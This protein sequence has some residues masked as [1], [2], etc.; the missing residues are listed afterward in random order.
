[1]AR[2]GWLIGAFALAAA[3][4]A[5]AQG[6]RQGLERFTSP[7][8]TRFSGEAEF[9]AYVAALRAAWR[10]RWSFARRGPLR[11]AQ[12]QP[13]GE[14]LRD[15]SPDPLCPEDNPNCL[16]VGDD[17]GDLGNITVTGSRIAPR[18]ASITNNQMQGVDEGDIVKQIGRFL[19]ILSDG[20]IFTIDTRP[21]GRPG[22]A[23]ASR[24]NVYLDPGID[25]WYDEMLVFGDRILVAGYSY[26]EEHTVLSVFRLDQAGR[27]SREGTFTRRTNDYYSA[28]NYATRLVGDSLVVYSIYNIEESDDLHAPFGLAS[29]QRWLPGPPQRRPARAAHERR[30]GDNPPAGP[31]L[32]GA[33]ELYRP[34]RLETR[35]SIHAFSVC[36]LGP[37]AERQALECRT[38]GFVGPEAAEW[39]VTAEE[40]L[41]WAV[42]VDLDRDAQCAGA[43]ASH[44]E[45]LPA[46]LFRVPHDGG[47]PG[48][49]GARGVPF[50]QFSLQANDG[51]LRALVDRI[52]ERCNRPYRDPVEPWY[53]EAPL[54]SLS[55]TYRELGQ[56]HY[57]EV[58]NPGMRNIAN[59]FTE[60]YLVYG[61]LSSYRG[62]P[63]EFDADD[64]DDDAEARAARQRIFARPPAYA[65]RAGHPEAVHRL[66]IGHNVIRAERYGENDIVLTGYRGRRGLSI[67][68][69]DL[70]GS[71]RIASTVELNGRFES[72]GRSHA[73]NSTIGEGGRG[74]MGLPTTSHD[75]GRRRWRSRAS[76]ISYLAVDGDR[77]RSLGEIVSTLQYDR[78]RRYDDEDDRDGLP[79]YEC[80]VSCIDWYGNSRPIFTDGRIF[81]LMGGELVEARRGPDRMVE[82]HRLDYLRARALRA[83]R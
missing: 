52:P 20:R 26:E 79:G 51:T 57:A 76:D 23:L 24:I 19:L 30:D 75:E 60:R 1:M 45:V 36:P 58:P 61:G 31:P 66:D 48:V 43:R 72:E 44:E 35:P 68:L 74:V 17:E 13:E 34:V 27:L 64:Y 56:R 12:A 37:L 2:I 4:G 7:T 55:A 8:L 10:E 82:I 15:N 46:V 69:I 3:S 62:G 53:F 47:A 32:V 78:G 21:G 14:V 5:G 38:T 71:P 59:R 67:S 77:L 18:N 28:N 11:F 63:P 33:T 39:Y 9:D 81:A 54:A 42:D 22:L 73:F 16:A 49:A 70:D 25:T 6:A 50:D 83:P 80:E 65:V 29:M 41:L 40:A